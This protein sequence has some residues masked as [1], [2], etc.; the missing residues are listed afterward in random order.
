ML[1]K[2]DYKRL[3]DRKELFFENAPVGR[4]KTLS[5]TLLTML[6]KLYLRNIHGACAVLFP[7]RTPV[8]QYLRVRIIGCRSDLYLM[9]DS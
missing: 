6:S 9:I 4:Y 3:K 2:N 1:G 7:V 8:Q 5:G